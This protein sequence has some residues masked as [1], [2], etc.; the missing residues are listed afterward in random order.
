MTVRRVGKFKI[1]NDIDIP[2]TNGVRISW[3]P[4]LETMQ[5]GESFLLPEDAPKYARSSIMQY[6]RMHGK[7]FIVRNTSEGRRCWR[8]A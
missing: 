2:E 1:S 6:G 7:T 3:K 5:V 4:I 8:V